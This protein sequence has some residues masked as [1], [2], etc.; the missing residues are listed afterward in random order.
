MGFCTECGERFERG[1]DFCQECGTKLPGTTDAPKGRSGQRK[2][3]PSKLPLI[4]MILVVS[5]GIAL[6]FGL[7]WVMDKSSN[8]ELAKQTETKKQKDSEMKEQE[9]QAESSSETKTVKVSSIEGKPSEETLSDEEKIQQAVVKLREQH[10]Q[11]ISVGEWSITHESG[12]RLR[13]EA[14]SIPDANLETIFALYDQRNLGPLE[15]WAKE[16]YEISA[17][18]GEALG[19]SWDVYV[20]N[21][22]VAQFPKRLPS[23]VIALYSGTCGSSIPVLTGTNREDFSLVIDER[24][25]TKERESDM[26]NG[27]ERGE[28]LLPESH[29]RR[30]SEFEISGLTKAELRLARNEIYARHGYVFNS[31]DLQRYF[32]AQ[33]W[34][35][36]IHTYDGMLTDIERYNVDLIKKVEDALP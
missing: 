5:L 1:Q 27:N 30:L 22:C 25:F 7:K 11:G 33:N 31:E 12:E 24:V 17:Q 34:Y 16:V 14:H 28:Y 19:T 26:Y 29:V 3:S 32:S 8:Q 20:G 35:F 2:R 13:I 18:L 6:F 23:N 15:V 4:M 10:I 21:H 9:E 36:P